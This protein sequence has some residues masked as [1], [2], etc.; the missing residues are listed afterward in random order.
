MVVLY[1]SLPTFCFS[2]DV[3]GHGTNTYSQRNLENQSLLSPPLCLDPGVG[4]RSTVME[5]QGLQSNGLEVGIGS[6]R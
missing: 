1:E 4:H 3:I 5:T 6:S 2:C